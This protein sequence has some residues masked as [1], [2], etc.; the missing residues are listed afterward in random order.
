M[1]KGIFADNYMCSAERDMATGVVREGVLCLMQPQKTP[2]AARVDGAQATVISKSSV[3][4]ADPPNPKCNRKFPKIDSDDAALDGQ[5][6][7]SVAL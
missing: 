4:E 1:G 5:G 3:G 7:G 2:A 6:Q